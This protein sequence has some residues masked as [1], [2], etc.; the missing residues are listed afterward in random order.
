MGENGA[1]AVDTAVL[2][3]DPEYLRGIINHTVA[4]VE[5]LAAANSFLAKEV[6][7][8]EAVDIAITER[9]H[10]KRLEN[11]ESLR[12]KYARIRNEKLAGMTEMEKVAFRD[13][14]K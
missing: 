6:L 11:N 4:R 7:P 12:E 13:A 9:Q 14:M 2:W 5:E 1:A 8:K 10:A 3:N